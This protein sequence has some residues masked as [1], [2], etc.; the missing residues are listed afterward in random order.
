MNSV[1][2]TRAI[3]ALCILLSFNSIAE[4]QSALRSTVLPEAEATRLRDTCSR[5]PVQF[6]ETW[7]P[8]NDVVSSLTKKLQ[9]LS[10]VTRCRSTRDSLLPS[11]KYH[12][13]YVGIVVGGR[14]LVYVNAIS[15]GMVPE[16]WQ[17]RFADICGGGPGAWS[18]FYDPANRVFSNLWINAGR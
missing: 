9:S 7:R 2:T 14:R 15:V 16:D 5:G 8:G 1:S 11:Y 4:G 17:T 12:F 3:A 18:V 13:Q 10:N 6:D